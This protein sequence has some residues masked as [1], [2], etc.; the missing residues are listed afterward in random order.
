MTTRRDFVR[1]S[2]TAVLGGLLAER[3]G[4]NLLAEDSKESLD[5]D[6]FMKRLSAHWHGDEQIAMLVYPGFTA[7]DLFGP[8][9]MFIS[10]SGAK[11]Q[12][13]AE[14][15]DVVKTDSGIGIVPTATFETCPEKLTILFIPGGTTG[16]LAACENPKVREFLTSRAPNCEYLASVCTGSLVLGAAGLLDGYRATSHWICRDQLRDFGAIPV[17]ERVVV[18]RNRITGAGVT[19]GLDFG[20]SLVQR[21]RG[22][23]YAEA[24]QLFSEYDPQPELKSGSVA[25]ADPALVK[26]LADMHQQFNQ[27]VADVA[28]RIQ[29]PKDAK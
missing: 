17:D 8:H 20:L 26:L 23:E 27:S 12:I 22:R 25:K 28:K 18:D 10:M 29:T 15:D 21:L 19:S 3:R 9:H 4:S 11:V 14:T 2:M 13:V 5:H 24:V 1:G 6:E 16:T 7:L